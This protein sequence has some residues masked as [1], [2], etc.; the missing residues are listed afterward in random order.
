MQRELGGGSIRGAARRLDAEPIAQV[1]PAVVLQLQA[2]HPNEAVPRSQP[3]AVPD[4][5]VTGDTLRQ[6]LRQLPRNSAP[7]PSGWTYEYLKTAV[8]SSDD[9]FD[10]VLMFVQ[11][12]VAG[13]LP[14]LPELFACRLIPLQKSS[15]GIRPIA[16]GEVWARLIA[17]CA[18]A[19]CPEVGPELLPFQCGVG[20][21]GGAQC[22]G[23][24][25]DAGVRAHIDAVTL[26]LDW[27]N[28]F[29]TV[30]RQAVL[31]AVAQ[32]APALYA[33][34]AWAYGA[35][36]HL[37]L[38]GAAPGADPLLSRTGV[39]QGDPSGPLLF[40]LSLQSCLERVATLHPQVAVV[41]Y[42]DDTFLQGP[43]D[44]VAAA[45]L[46]LQQFGADMGL[47]CAPA[48]SVVYCGH[49]ASASTVA[50]ALGWPD[51]CA[52]DDGIVAA[53]SPLGDQEFV[54]EHIHTAAG[55]VLAQ[56]HDLMQ[57]PLPVQS[58]LLLLRKSVQ[59]RLRHLPRTVRY[60]RL[61]ADLQKVEEGVMEA[62]F[63]LLGREFRDHP[64]ALMQAML[65][66]RAGGF[67]LLPM[68]GADS[69][70]C[71]AAYLSQAALTH[72]AFSSG[73]VHFDPFHGPS[74]IWL[75]GCVRGISAAL[76]EVLDKWPESL[77]DSQSVSCV[78]FAGAQSAVSTAVAEQLSSLL[79]ASYDPAAEGLSDAQRQDRRSHLARLLSVA[80]P[81]SS[82]WLD[83][84]PTRPAL[85]LS[86]GDVVASSRFRLG[87]CP[88]PE[89]PPSSCR[90]LCA[91]GNAL[92]G[93]AFDHA[94]VCPAM[95]P[96]WTLRHNLVQ[97]AWRDLGQPAG[98]AT[99]IE[100]APRHL[101]THAV[102][103]G[104]PGHL[105]RG[106]VLF[107]KDDILLGDVAVVHPGQASMGA[108]PSTV[109]GHAA[110]RRSA[111]K[112][113]KHAAPGFTFVPLVM[114]TYGR[115][116][117]EARE[118]LRTLCASVHNMDRAA[119]LQYGRSRL[120]VALVKGN[121]IVFRR[122]YRLLAQAAGRD[123]RPGADVPG[124]DAC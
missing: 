34:T 46:H 66:L 31:D 104:A 44:A 29:N 64:Q 97:Y 73:P 48:K 115:L 81:V 67:G 94:M 41:A 117:Q 55:K 120:S 51:D 74:R 12:G 36:S 62:F 61:K 47:H 85:V 56:L 59:H 26:Q 100:A 109:P 111:D 89:C 8:R 83:V 123:F 18:V 91:C 76:G 24:A 112:T 17:L 93:S 107:V 108:R 101:A 110:D 116:G 45:C 92:T 95:P 90:V 58:K 38:V 19:A 99:A 65:P 124:F 80:D 15:G 11:A 114:E 1:T 75:D 63:A 70:L 78:G 2:L 23:L 40:A 30:S 32:R 79:R 69:V 20:V 21:P 50:A 82:A 10:A 43:P 105:R 14:P 49:R 25:L 33:Y 88:G 6:V 106:D 98:Y 13:T 5:V 9:A 7:G 96:V 53:G 16:I 121:G 4:V 103:L 77:V 86:D 27:R 72:A 84:L 28:A 87:M 118:F 102:P 37:H 68:V 42:A 39:R 60:F 22:L 119:A 57:L 52:T 54:E 3:P 71:D 35:H 122:C 113:R